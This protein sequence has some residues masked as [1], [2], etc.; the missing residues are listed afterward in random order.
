MFNKS[1]NLQEILLSS[2]IIYIGSDYYDKEG[3]LY[4]E[5]E[6]GESILFPFDDFCESFNSIYD[7]EDII[8]II[9]GFLNS[10]RLGDKLIK[11]GYSHIIMLPN[12]KYLNNLF[13]KNPTYIIQYKEFLY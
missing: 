5:G 6:D 1:T 3:N 8:L 9:L 10:E 2:R 4:Y 7:K 12:I 13:S 11:L